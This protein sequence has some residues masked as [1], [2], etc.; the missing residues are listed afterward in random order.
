[1]TTPD[2]DL[3]VLLA[4]ADALRDADNMRDKAAA[5]WIFL[6]VVLFKAGI[7]VKK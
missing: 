5:V 2:P 4:D 7:L 3:L 1:M 6:S